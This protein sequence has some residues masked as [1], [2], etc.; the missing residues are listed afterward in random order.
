MSFV[1]D[2]GLWPLARVK[3]LTGDVNWISDFLCH[4]GVKCGITSGIPDVSETMEGAFVTVP[5]F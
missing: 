3:V 4:E 2:L 1:D 5:P